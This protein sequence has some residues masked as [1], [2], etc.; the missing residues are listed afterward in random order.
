MRASEHWRTVSAKE[1]VTL[2][3]SQVQHK[4]RFHCE[5]CKFVISS[6]QPQSLGNRNEEEEQRE[7]TKVITGLQ[8]QFSAG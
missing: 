6:L 1:N 4:H 7:E 2:P 8:K 5:D 3:S